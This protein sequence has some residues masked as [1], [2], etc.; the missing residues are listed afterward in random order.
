[1][2]S[3]SRRRTS[4]RIANGTVSG[5]A[6][7]IVIGWRKLSNCA[8]STMYMNRMLSPKAIPKLALLSARLFAR[9]V[10]CTL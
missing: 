3:A 2:L 1:M 7:M 5:S 9:P 10:Q 4:E 6:S 8:A